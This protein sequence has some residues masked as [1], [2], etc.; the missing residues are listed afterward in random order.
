MRTDE[1]IRARGRAS[2]YTPAGSSNRSTSHGMN[3]NPIKAVIFDIGDVVV[4]VKY[5]R[6]YKYAAYNLNR[7]HRILTGREDDGENYTRLYKSTRKFNDGVIEIVRELKAAGYR[8]PVLSNAEHNK[9]R[10]AKEFGAY[11]HFEPLILSAEV[12]LE[13]PDR[14]IF[15][16]AAKRI[17][18]KP[19]ECVFVDDKKRNADAAMQVGFNAIVFKNAKQLR[20]DLKKHGVKIG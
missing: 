17:G 6:L 8:V 9:I 19:E 5:G 11:D 1:A 7:L 13:K 18:L 14:R 3:K 10:A 2:E 12:G 16:L 15:E 20:K 4:G